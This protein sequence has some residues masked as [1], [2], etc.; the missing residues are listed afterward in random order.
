MLAAYFKQRSKAMAVPFKAISQPIFRLKAY[1]ENKIDSAP[2]LK[3]TAHKLMSSPAFASVAKE[4]K[5][6][7][8][9]VTVLIEALPRDRQSLKPYLASQQKALKKWGSHFKTT[10]VAQTAR[11]KSKNGSK[12]SRNGAKQKVAPE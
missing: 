2:A 4:V 10:L 3:K 7:R 9:H 11:A 1:L 5:R 8:K 12:R 6:G